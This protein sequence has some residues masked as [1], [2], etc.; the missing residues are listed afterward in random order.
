MQLSKFDPED[1]NDCIKALESSF[2]VQLSHYD[3]AEVKTFGDLCDVFENT[4]QQENRN[5][6]TTQ[7]A[8][9]KIRAAI[10]ESQGIDKETIKPESRLTYLLPRK[11]RRKRV[12]LLEEQ[13]GIKLHML[14]YPVWL[15]LVLIAG[16][17]A[18]LITLGFNWK[19]G[20]SGLAISYLAIWIADKTAKELEHQTV[21]E[22]TE[23]TAA[24]NYQKMRRI[25]GTVNRKEI[26]ASIKEVFCGHLGIDTAELTNEAEF[27]QKAVYK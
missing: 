19:T 27:F 23:K 24:L 10:S 7:Q 9:Y 4:I 17:I 12:R 8:F 20:L 21:R 18:S 25:S 1:I 26:V 15:T 14:T 11:S 2:G 5:D 6:C 22:L 13:L 3:L 16:F